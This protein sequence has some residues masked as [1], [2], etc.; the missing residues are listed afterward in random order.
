MRSTIRRHTRT[1]AVAGAGALLLASCSVD[2]LLERGLSMVEG[3]EGVEIDRDGGSFA[4]RSEEGELFAIDIDEEEGTASFATEEGSVTTGQASE[5]P[6]EIAAVF[7]PP[8][9]F[10]VQAVSDMSS[11]E[12]GRGLLAQGEITGDWSELMD[13]IE[14]AVQAGPWDEVQ[15]QVMQAGVMGIVIGGREDGSGTLNASLMME[16]GAQEGMLSVLLVIPPET[17][18]GQ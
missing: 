9:G 15:R 18:E 16:E 2:G 4:I 10:Q 8:P 14:A 17:L 12:D 1:L 13:T 11:T 7:S 6:S 3:V 5:L